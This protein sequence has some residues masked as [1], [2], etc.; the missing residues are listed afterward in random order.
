MSFFCWPNDSLD[1][2]T[3]LTGKDLVFWQIGILNLHFGQNGPKETIRIEVGFNRILEFLSPW[4]SSLCLKRPRKFCSNA[5]YYQLDLKRYCCHKIC[6]G[7]KTGQS[8]QFGCGQLSASNSIQ[9]ASSWNLSSSNWNICLFLT[10][11]NT[12]A[13]CQEYQFN[14]VSTFPPPIVKFFGWRWWSIWMEISRKKTQAKTSP[15]WWYGGGWHLWLS[16][17]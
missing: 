2:V 14:A 15:W 9:K 10:S 6:D 3:P 13:L 11:T 16:E 7:N 12:W 1:C 4:D 8:V 17:C 5:F